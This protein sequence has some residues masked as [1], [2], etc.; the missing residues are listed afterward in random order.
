MFLLLFL[1]ILVMVTAVTVTVG[2]A[3]VVL[4][5]AARRDRALVAGASSLPVSKMAPILYI[6]GGLLGLATA[7]TFGYNLLSPWLVI[8]YVL[9]AMFALL[10]ITYSGPTLERLHAVAA[11]ATLDGE[12]FGT[13]IRRFQV[14]TFL[15]YAGIVLLV[16]DMVFKPFS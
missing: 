11:D 12:A 9:F 4:V 2:T 1:H 15:T 6:S 3:L 8:A 16:A 13:A 7:L 5:A 10:G 14:D